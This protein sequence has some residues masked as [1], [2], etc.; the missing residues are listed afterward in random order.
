MKNVGA[1]HVT[2]DNRITLKITDTQTNFT[3]GDLNLAILNLYKKKRKIMHNI[4]T[5]YW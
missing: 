3:A 2:S 1:V 5:G 4:Q